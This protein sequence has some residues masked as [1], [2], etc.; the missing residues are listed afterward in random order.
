MPSRK[1]IQMAVGNIKTAKKLRNGSVLLEVSS[2]V[3]ADRA[4]AMTNWIDTPV[5]V[6]AHRSLNSSKGVIRC[7]EFRDCE[8]DEVLA[9][10]S[11]QEYLL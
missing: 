8:D 6:T 10:L 5:K 9:A 3:Q 2:K 1:V 7:R 4:L 11:T